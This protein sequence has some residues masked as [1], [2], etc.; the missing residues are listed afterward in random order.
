MVRLEACSTCQAA[1]ATAE[2]TCNISIS[3]FLLPER[4]LVKVTNDI[5]NAWNIDIMLI[6]TG[7]LKHE[8]ESSGIAIITKEG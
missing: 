8:E 2:K 6:L 4:K 7:K 5:G 3:C 1:L